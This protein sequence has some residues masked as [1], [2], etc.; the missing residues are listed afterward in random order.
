LVNYVEVNESPLSPLFLAY[1]GK[2]LFTHYI[3][4]GASTKIL[5]QFDKDESLNLT[6][7]EISNDLLTHPEFNIS[8]RPAEIIPTPFVIN[9]AIIQQKSFQF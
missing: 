9:D 3:S 5:L 1:R 4:D 7:N 6:I 8:D 2:R